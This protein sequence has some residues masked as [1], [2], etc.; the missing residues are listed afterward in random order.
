VRIAREL[1]LMFALIVTPLVLWYGVAR[2]SGSMHD[3]GVKDRTLAY[4]IEV[5]RTPPAADGK[6]AAMRAWAV[7]I[8]DRYSGVPIDWRLQVALTPATTPAVPTG[9]TPAGGKP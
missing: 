9:V 2:I 1:A 6:D 4:A 5:L 7:R 8:L 3:A